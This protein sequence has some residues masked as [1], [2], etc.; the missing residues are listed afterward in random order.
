LPAYRGKT[1]GTADSQ[2][3]AMNTFGPIPGKQG[4]AQYTLEV[5]ADQRALAFAFSDL[6]IKVGGGK[7]PATTATRVASFVLPLEGEEERVE[8]EFIIQGY[9]ATIEAA[10]A[11]VV[12]SVNGQTTLTDVPGP[13]SDSFVQKLTFA[14]KKPSACR[15]CIFLLLGRDSKNPNAEGILTVSTIDAELLPRPR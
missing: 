3:V 6:E 8:M 10:T 15:L 1:N 9:I 2:E 5:S 11:T 7:S 12:C 14:A 13:M 4:D